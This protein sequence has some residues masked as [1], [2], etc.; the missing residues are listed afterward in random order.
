MLR[1]PCRGARIRSAEG[2]AGVR[3]TTTRVIPSSP[4]DTW[5]LLCDSR[6]RLRPL[7]PVF[8]L[9][10][11]RPHECALPSGEGGPGAERECRS[12][13]GTVHQRITVWE[14]PARLR[15]HMETTT[16]GFGRHLDALE[17]DFVLVPHPRGTRVT[18]TTTVVARGWLKPVVSAM[19]LVGLKSVHR[20]VFRNWQVAPQHIPAADR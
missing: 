9:G 7:C 10:A 19:V 5:R 13:A 20:F 16:L 11:P 4:A 14:P 8:Y 1:D 15:F 12:T 18:R 17:D 2:G 6:L 3:V